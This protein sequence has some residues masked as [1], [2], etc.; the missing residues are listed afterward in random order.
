MNLFPFRWSQTPSYILLPSH[1][2]RSYI[3]SPGGQLELL[4][5]RPS[6]DNA[7]R[8]QPILFIHGGFGSAGVRLPWMTV[9]SQSYH[10]PCY[11]VSLR[12]HGASWDPGFLMM[13]ALTTKAMLATDVVAAVEEVEKGEKGEKLCLLAIAVEEV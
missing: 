6:A 4:H 10:Y 3:N 2:D 12:G 1:V 9:L 5:A 8:K 11:A 13:W 7:P